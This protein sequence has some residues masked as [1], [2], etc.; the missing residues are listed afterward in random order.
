[1]AEFR[2]FSGRIS[3]AYYAWVGFGENV[4]RTT[5]GGDDPNHELSKDEKDRLERQLRKEAERDRQEGRPRDRTRK[6]SRAVNIS[7]PPSRKAHGS[8]KSR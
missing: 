5:L 1:M 2:P 4:P 8:D 3:T 6:L 7:R